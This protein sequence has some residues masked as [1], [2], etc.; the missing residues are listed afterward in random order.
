MERMTSIAKYMADD[1]KFYVNTTIKAT[2]T[3]YRPTSAGIYFCVHCSNPGVA[4]DRELR[5]NA[6]RIMCAD[7]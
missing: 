1:I 7:E 3:T 6:V 2:L 5:V 4:A